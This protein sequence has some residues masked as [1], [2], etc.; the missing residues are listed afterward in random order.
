MQIFLKVLLTC[1]TFVPVSYKDC[2][3]LPDGTYKVKHTF[4]SIEP[5]SKLKIENGLYKQRWSNGDTAKGKVIWY[6]QCEFRL[7][8]LDPT[9][10]DTTEMGKILLKSFGVPVFELQ[11]KRGDT[12]F[13]RTTFSANLHLTGSK[14]YMLKVN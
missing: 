2:D 4:N 14:G 7:E 12:I 9:K 5:E 1:L 10:V 13:F 3:L 11:D 6:Y 8:Q